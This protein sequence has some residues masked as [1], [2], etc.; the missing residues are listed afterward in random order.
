MAKTVTTINIPTTQL[1]VDTIGGIRKPPVYDGTISGV[2]IV[3]E[4]WVEQ[5]KTT[6]F[7]YYVAN[8]LWKPQNPYFFSRE[9]DKRPQGSPYLTLIWIPNGDQSEY[10]GGDPSWGRAV[11][12]YLEP[13][14]ELRVSMKDAMGSK[15]RAKIKSQRV[16]LGVFLAER[17]QTIDLFTSAA[18]RVTRAYE[19]VRR[20]NFRKAFEEL[21]CKPSR[22]L[23]ARKTAAQNWLELQYGWVPVLGDVYGAAQELEQS[24]IRVRKR[25][26]I[27]TVGATQ[28]WSNSDVW[29][30]E[31]L[32]KS[33]WAERQCIYIARM[34]V[35]YTVDVESAA[36]LG[37]VGLTNPFSI[38]WEKS[39]WSFVVDWWL[40]IGS[41]LN[42]L[43]AL[44]GC[45]FVGGTDSGETRSRTDYNRI[46]TYDVGNLRYKYA[47]TGMSGRFFKYERGVLADFPPV[48]LP[49]FKNPLSAQ[50]CANALALLTQVFSKK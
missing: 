42:T 31:S 39:P 16:N 36:F 28:R 26:P 46:G 9:T 13:S 25:P 33:A 29:R 18:R 10:F 12:P 24:F 48:S 8:N 30:N 23:N 50:H 35:A 37:R 43:D 40:P 21:R 34:K 2:G 44:L 20:K 1:R 5:V 7:G 3:R 15:C 19:A 41:F 49:Q 22:R 47:Y 38:A 27:L 14:Q 11:T 45:N 4:K 17:T 6:N 32:V